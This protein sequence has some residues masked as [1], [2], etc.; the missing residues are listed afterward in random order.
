MNP[1]HYDLIMLA[2]LKTARKV[3][4][5]FVPKIMGH[6]MAVNPA[7]PQVVCMT[8][9]QLV[10]TLFGHWQNELVLTTQDKRNVRFN[11]KASSSALERGAGAQ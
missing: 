1:L 8:F 4:A 3:G 2:M 10:P 5:I 6:T 11:G 9:T 7:T